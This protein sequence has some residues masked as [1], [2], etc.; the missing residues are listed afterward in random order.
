MLKVNQIKRKWIK[1][2]KLIREKKE[3][4]EERENV[5]LES[6]S[7]NNT[8]AISLRKRIKSFEEQTI[9]IETLI[10]DLDNLDEEKVSL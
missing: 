3:K 4:L 2:L 9:L 1:K 6:N 5:Y 8:Q 10:E 7:L